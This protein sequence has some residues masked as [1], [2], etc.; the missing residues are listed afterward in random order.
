MKFHAIGD[1]SP[2]NSLPKQEEL[3][4]AEASFCEKSD[5]S[6]VVPFQ[7]SEFFTPKRKNTRLICIVPLYRTPG[8]AATVRSR[9]PSVFFCTQGVPSPA[10]GFIPV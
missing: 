9:C 2:P 5:T 3:Q 6:Y 4:L 10:V 1:S 7:V 8:Q